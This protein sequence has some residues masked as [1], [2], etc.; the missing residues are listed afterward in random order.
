MHQD[1]RSKVA[2]V[3]KYIPTK[4]RTKV[5]SSILVAQVLSAS[6]VSVKG[7]SRALRIEKWTWS[8]GK[9]PKTHMRKRVDILT[10]FKTSYSETSEGRLVIEQERLVA[11]VQHSEMSNRTL[12]R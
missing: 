10:Q 2:P 4:P 6:A 9:C 12:E 5:T 11:I 7:V 1:G 8:S 3:S